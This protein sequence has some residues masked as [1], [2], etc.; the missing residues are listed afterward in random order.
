MAVVGA[1]ALMHAVVAM[2][3]LQGGRLNIALPPP[4][5][6][7]VSLVPVPPPAPP[8]QP[9]RAPDRL[10]V[11]PIDIPP[12]PV[13]QALPLEPV[14]PRPTPAVSPAITVA[15]LPAAPASAPQEPAP[16]PSPRMLPASAV[17]YLQPPAPV[18]PR[19]SRRAGEA[20]RVVV[21]LFIDEAGLPRHVQ[22]SQSC[23]H[24][25]LDEAAVVAVQNARFKPATHNGAP[26]SGWALIPLTFDLET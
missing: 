22:V 15:A 10:P 2:A 16:G 9:L 23:G 7:M 3:L 26:L 5:P 13:P 25:R 20:G 6:L 1:I 21:R 14:V 11:L 18:Y 8:A 17:Q 12:P 19:A 24:A 4:S